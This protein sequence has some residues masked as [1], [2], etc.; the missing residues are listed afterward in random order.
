MLSKLDETIFQKL[1]LHH[2][3]LFSSATRDFIVFKNQNCQLKL[4]TL[5]N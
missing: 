5:F 2:Q 3:V 4:Q 1:N